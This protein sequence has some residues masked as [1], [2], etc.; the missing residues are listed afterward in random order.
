MV[1]GFG[2]GLE[3]VYKSLL[4]TWSAMILDTPGSQ[5]PS[6]LT[7]IP[8]VK[9]RNLR[10][11]MSHRYEPS[12]LTNTGGGRAYVASMYF[13][14]WFTMAA[15]CEPSTGSA[16]G[17]A[18][19]GVL[20]G[21]LVAAAAWDDMNRRPEAAS[22]RVGSRKAMANEIVGQLEY[23]GSTEGNNPTVDTAPMSLYKKQCW[24]N[25]LIHPPA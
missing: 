7:A 21:T 20:R 18:T 24:E 25:G 6:P 3:M 2:N 15:L 9:S 10:F 16:F 13:W 22:L 11:S 1:D 4:L 19:G 5:W 12:P 17:G 14:C 23:G 8:D